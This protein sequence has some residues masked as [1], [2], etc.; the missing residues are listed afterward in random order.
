MLIATRF[1]ETNQ[2]HEVA[3]PKGDRKQITFF[4]EPV[5]DG[6]YDGESV[7][8]R[9]DRGGNEFYQYAR[10][11]DGGSTLLTDGK[12][13][14]DGLLRGPNG[15]FAFSSTR[16]NST[17]HDIF[18]LE[19]DGKNRL[20]SEEKGEWRPVA[21]SRDGKRLIVRNDVSIV[22]SRLAS[23]EVESG[24][25]TILL[26]HVGKVAYGS[27]A[28]DA[29]GRLWLI[30][31]EGGE[32]RDLRR[33]DGDKL[34]LVARPGER[35]H[36]VD[37][38]EISPDGKR[39]AFTVNAG[40]ETLLYVGT[41]DGNWKRVELP[42][43]VLGGRMRFDT[44]SELLGLTWSSA[45]GSDCWAVDK[46]GHATRWTFSE[47]GGL[48][49][50]R[51]VDPTLVEWKSFDGRTISGWLYRPAVQKRPAVIINIHGG[52]ESQ[53]TVAFN[54]LVQLWVAQLGVAVLL[55][56]VRGSAG[57]G[58]SFLEL[59]NG[60]RRLDS[61][62]DIGTLLDSL[63]TRTDVDSSRVA[64]YGGSYG[65]FMVLASLVAFS[66]RLRCGV[67]MVG[68]SNFV[69]FLEHTESY[70]RD[71]RRAEYGDERD[72][73]IR[74]ALVEAS[75]LTHADRIKRPLF[76]AQG[77]N[78]PR[79]PLGEAEQIVHTLRNQGGQ[80]WYLMASDEGHGF[81]KRKNRD[82]FIEAGI[83]FFETVLLP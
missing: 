64:V 13:R 61:V 59:D 78:D 17:D 30:S 40:G 3:A 10:L 32:F 4:G 20:V 57:F 48:D 29:R 11:G 6:A 43:G 15:R 76:V 33:L 77:K 2:L 83:L 24:A 55:P 34:E 25:Q 46:T 70:R 66:D 22:E 23:V 41:V 80:V 75:P 28:Y 74:T 12:S 73:T 82:A 21:W 31:D 36:D 50:T 71:Q 56:N 27:A 37:G 38:L 58:R 51:F 52:P 42:R 62:K 16:R 65:G 14:N 72:P 68:I 79:V 47:T 54:P 53:S 26:P 19:I 49:T 63:S 81:Q 45:R 18:V 8:Y 5:S 67:D 69:T 60:A 9:I 7:I 1:G 39:V 44:R 35:N